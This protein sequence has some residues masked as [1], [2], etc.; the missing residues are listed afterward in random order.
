MA[1]DCDDLKY[2]CMDELALF[3]CFTR[4]LDLQAKLP[5]NDIFKDEQT[6]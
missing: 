3:C 1:K 5:F 2:F 4:F 6:T